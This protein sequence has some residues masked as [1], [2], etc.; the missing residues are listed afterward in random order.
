MRRDL[1]LKLAGAALSLGVIMTPF[2]VLAPR[3]MVDMVIFDQLGRH[4][5]DPGIL[6]RLRTLTS[7]DRISS[8]LH[9]VALVVAL[10]ALAAL[11]VTTCVATL[12]AG[13]ARLVAVLT[14]AQLTVLLVA[15]SFYWFY[16]DYAAPGAALTLAVAA[17]QVVRAHAR[18]S[19]GISGPSVAPPDSDVAG[20]PV[21]AAGGP[22]TRGERDPGGERRPEPRQRSFPAAE[23]R[24]VGVDEA[25]VE[26]EQQG[27]HV[28]LTRDQPG[29]PVP[30]GGVSP[31]T[32]RY[33]QPPEQV[34]TLVASSPDHEY[35]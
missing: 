28:E 20:D 10:V 24:R 4:D 14:I 13:P 18:A 2:F 22:G 35:A 8:H 5:N 25:A 1:G 15:P 26:V 23:N 17:H 11:F 34:K 16:A 31:K 27:G 3:Q 33:P 6:D 19:A 12:L 32:I 30:A 21:G 9:S 29:G 7:L